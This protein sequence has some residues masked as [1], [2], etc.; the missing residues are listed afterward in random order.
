MLHIA[1]E[2][3]HEPVVR[4]LLEKGADISS[5]DSSGWNALHHAVSKGHE[6]VVQLL[7]EK[8]ADISS[9]DS[10]GWNALHHAVSKGHELVVQLLLEK[11][12]DISSTNNSGWNALHRAASDGHEPVNGRHNGGE[13]S[14]IRRRERR[15]EVL[16]LRYTSALISKSVTAYIGF[17]IFSSRGGL[18][19]TC[20]GG[21]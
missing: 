17:P 15:S 16:E 6:P 3:G 10:S 9:T 20:S 7:L 13:I 1:V 2:F 14:P 18:I 4:L 8:G 11:G 5:T 19:T 21:Q 12:A